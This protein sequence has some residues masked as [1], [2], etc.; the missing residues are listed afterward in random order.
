MAKRD[1]QLVLKA[2]N[3]ADAAVKTL[4]GA[5]EK[6]LGVQNDLSGSGE[7]TG[8]TID[9][10]AS[11]LKTADAA[12]E[13]IAGAAGK[14]EASLA[15]AQGSLSAN[16]ARYRA[17]GAQVRNAEQAIVGAAVAMREDGTAGAA[18]RLGAAQA[19]WRDLQSEIGQVERT[20]TGQRAAV[21]T[22]ESG[23]RGMQNTVVAA[24]AA[25]RE[26]GDES[27]R[28][29]LRVIAAKNDERQAFL[30]AAQAARE[31]AQ[32]RRQIEGAQA[33][34]NAA[35]G[36]R[37]ID[38]G[39]AR[40]SAAVFE[41]AAR[42][43]REAAAAKAAN[44]E[45]AERLR[46][47]LDPLTAAEQKHSAALAEAKRLYDAAEISAEEYAQA[48]AQA[49]KNMA[50]AAQAVADNSEAARSARE[51]A[52]AEREL[53]AAASR[54]MARVDPLS[55][56]MDRLNAE[57]SEAKA[58]YHSGKI[59]LSQYTIAQRQLEAQIKDTAA[60]QERFNRNGSNEIKGVFGLRPYELQNL[61]YQINDVFTQL[62][63]GTPITQTFAQ[64]GGQI[65]QIFP[66]VLTGFVK[67]AR[68][69]ALVGVA[70]APIIIGMSRMKELAGVQRDFAASLEL[71]GRKAEY[72][73]SA[74]TESVRAMDEYGASVEDAT[75][76][77]KVFINEGIA[78]DKIEA[79]GAAS[80]DAAKVLGVDLKEAAEGSAKAFSSGYDAVAEFDDKL[81]FLTVSE[82]EQIR[83]MFES[84]R[85]SEAREMA[86]DRFYQKVQD[87]A[88][89]SETAFDRMTSAMARA[90]Q[91][92]EDY[93]SNSSIFEE[94]AY[95]FETLAVRIAY[96]FNRL[97]GMSEQEAADAARGTDPNKATPG[98]DTLDEGGAKREKARREAL[99]DI[100]L[101]RKALRAKG[102]AQK[103]AIAGER[104]YAAEMRKSGDTV[105]A[106]AKKELAVQQALSSGRSK[107]GGRGKS[108]GDRQAE[109]N[110]E[111][112]RQNKAR[113]IEAGQVT[114][115]NRLRG[116]ALI[117]E[118]R[119]QAIVDAIAKAEERA[120]KGGKESLKLT[121]DRR[122]EIARTVGL[123]FD[124][125]NE[126]AVIQ[127][128]RNEAEERLN[129]LLEDRRVLLRAAEFESPGTAAYAQVMRNVSDI[130]TEIA[131]ARG[132]IVGFWNDV[133]GDPE[134][135]ALL[136]TTLAKV[137]QVIATLRTGGDEIS[138]D[139]I[140][141]AR[142]A[143]EQGLQMLSAQRDLVQEQ[144]EFAQKNGEPGRAGELQK[145][146]VE[147][148]SRL[149]E[150][151]QNAIAFWRVIAGNP[152]YLAL[153]G[154]TAEEVQNIIMGLENTIAAS[155]NMRTQFL[156]SGEDINRMAAQMGTNAMSQFAQDLVAGQNAI[157]SLALAF[158]NFA[159]DFLMQ[160][161]EMIAMQAIF[162]AISGETG[163]GG[164]GGGIA[165]AMG[166][167]FAAA[168]PLTA[169]AAGLSGAGA[170][171]A[172]AGATLAGAGGT[173]T[174]GGTAVA[175]GSGVLT[176]AVTAGM[177]FAAAL[178]AAATT[179][180]IANSMSAGSGGVFHGGGVVG[181]KGGR[182][183]AVS[184][185][186]FAGATRYHSGGVVGLKPN[187]VPIIAERG[188]EMLTREDPRHRA[189]GG[190]GGGGDRGLT[191]ILAIGEDQVARAMA[192]RAGGD[193]VLTHIRTNRASIR[194]LLGI[195]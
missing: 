155:Q 78:S 136:D 162:N 97:Q 150:G 106:A 24:Q 73:A 95:R 64:Q 99:A 55:A 69:L 65:L 42:A 87:G 60:A 72:Q 175:A 81:G 105:I 149:A 92:L 91:S 135:I 77:V 171:L 74:L 31:E 194:E 66:R 191:Q 56:K 132:E 133:A 40:R 107:R 164:L 152:E 85:A 114:T 98:G 115:T 2:R 53:E 186:L 11:A 117:L 62:A 151:A 15:A 45:A 128:Q 48:R 158:A 71:S 1:V 88:R 27:E 187:E 18:A 43:E 179:L 116:T 8:D 76:A 138:R 51:A 146:L 139:G 180:L 159:A 9:R 49:D 25:M 195:R 23:F 93:L 170:A 176:G 38:E 54:L 36:V 165:G 182:G 41:E 189:N 172:G 123:E 20:L 101:D 137:Q 84:G 134:K 120:V 122:A 192:G 5:L 173:L 121:Q 167:L 33:Q 141:R 163:G 118:Q 83:A 144:I 169:A 148:N 119:R 140:E 147:V 30:A 6:L 125:K 193:M 104:A 61:S 96:I 63:S 13:A 50:G 86:F 70:M 124:A 67:Y 14:A 90:W 26:F 82:R 145:R 112:D 59:S 94:M 160:I 168:A 166:S 10:L 68:G 58:L 129:N 127:A 111:I 79:F 174:A 181:G 161:A 21:E 44:A 188:E 185:A 184:S 57:M 113:E 103:A 143:A 37:D 110:A 157:E 22:A 17:L 46:A 28:A 142:A 7:R 126:K 89:E 4:T 52:E 29:S 183:R 102:D 108:L 34:F 39:A 178:Q 80:I 32:Q 177:A 47:K 131:E 19:A 75:A 3:E 100:E 109:F 35:A 190:K 156:A 16:E 130:E 153:M 12:Y 154:R